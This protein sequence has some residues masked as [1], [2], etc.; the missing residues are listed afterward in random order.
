MTREF[1]KGKDLQLSEH[2]KLSEMDCKC[3]YPECQE[4]YVSNSLIKAFEELRLVMG[5]LIVL[6]GYRC[7]PH[8]V[9]VLG[10]PDSL[11]KIGCAIDLT[12]KNK[13]PYELLAAAENVAAFCES[14]L[15]LYGWG[16]HADVGRIKPARWSGLTNAKGQGK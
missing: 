7:E 15:G 3:S 13:T 14:G 2:L 11:H 9:D 1:E 5:P 6:S 16:I 10:K 4:T 12:S 8:N